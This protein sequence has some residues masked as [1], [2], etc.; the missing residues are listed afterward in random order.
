MSPQSNK[1]QPTNKPESTSG[2]PEVPIPGQTEP[3]S[4]IQSGLSITNTSDDVVMEEIEDPQN[5]NNN[6][7]Q[8]SNELDSTLPGSTPEQKIIK[9]VITP[10]NY[11][12]DRVLTPKNKGSLLRSHYEAA[13]DALLLATNQTPEQK[14]ILKQEYNDAREK[15]NIYKELKKETQ[16]DTASNYV[17]KNMPKLQIQDSKVR[18]PNETVHESLDAFIS[19]FEMKLDMYKLPLNQN[20]ERL[21]QGCI[22]HSQL[23]WFRL[24]LPRRTVQGTTIAW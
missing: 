1:I 15:Y 17:P 2:Q 20:W 18:Y 13:A 24:E 10:T 9:T 4:P 11:V 21:F 16:D 5:N 22:H 3:S 14:A 6:K 7:L 8:T 12:A 19:A 23:P